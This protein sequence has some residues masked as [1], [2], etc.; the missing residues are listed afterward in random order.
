MPELVSIVIDSVEIQKREFAAITSGQVNAMWE[1]IIAKGL[2][3]K[4]L[5][6]ENIPEAFS[7]ALEDQYSET[8]VSTTGEH[9]PYIRPETLQRIRWMIHYSSL[10]QEYK[11][12]V[13]F[14]LTTIDDNR[15]DLF[16]IF[17]GINAGIYPFTIL[18]LNNLIDEFLDYQD[19]IFSNYV[20]QNIKIKI[21]NSVTV[22]WLRRIVEKRRSLAETL[23]SQS[24]TL[25]DCNV[26]LSNINEAEEVAQLIKF[27][28]PKQHIISTPITAAAAGDG[29]YTNYFALQ[30]ELTENKLIFQSLSH[31]NNINH[32]I[33]I[34]PEGFIFL[35][36]VYKALAPDQPFN[37][38]FKSCFLDD[39]FFHHLP[40]AIILDEEKI[41]TLAN[42]TEEL[43]VCNHE[44]TPLQQIALEAL[45][46]NSTKLKRL[47]LTS[48]Y[49]TD[50]N[51]ATIIETLDKNLNITYL[52]LRGNNFTTAGMTQ[53][54]NHLIEK[55]FNLCNFYTDLFEDD[56]AEK[57]EHI[58][59]R[60]NN[61]KRLT[62]S[63]DRIIG[64]ITD[65][66]LVY[67]NEAINLLM[68]YYS[69]ALGL[70][71]YYY[72]DTAELPQK[73]K[74]FIADTVNRWLEEVA[75]IPREYLLRCNL[76]LTRLPSDKFPEIKLL[77]VIL[78]LKKASEFICVE[79]LLDVTLYQE[80][81]EIRSN[82]LYRDNAAVISRWQ[83]FIAATM[84][85]LAYQTTEYSDDSI[86]CFLYCYEFIKRL[87]PASP[88]TGINEVKVT[89]QLTIDRWII[90]APS[91][92]E[93]LV[94]CI[95]LLTKLPKEK[96]LEEL[97]DGLSQ[98]VINLIAQTLAEEMTDDLLR[99]Y[100]T[101]RQIIFAKGLY[102][103]S[104]ELLRVIYNRLQPPAPSAP[105][106]TF[107][108]GRTVAAAAAAAAT[109][110][111]PSDLN[112]SQQSMLIALAIRIINDF[113]DSR[114]I[115]GE[116]N[117][118][119]AIIENELMQNFM[120][121]FIDQMLKQVT[122]ELQAINFDPMNYIEPLA[123]TGGGG[124][125]EKSTGSSF[126]SAAKLHK[127][128]T[129]LRLWLAH[130]TPALYNSIK[131]QLFCLSL[132]DRAIKTIANT[133]TV[134]F[135]QEVK[136]TD[137]IVPFLT[138]LSTSTIISATSET[139][140]ANLEELYNYID[141]YK[142]Q[143]ASHTGRAVSGFFERSDRYTSRTAIYQELSNQ[144][145]LIVFECRQHPHCSLATP[146]YKKARLMG[147]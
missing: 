71:K 39:S 10:H 57:I 7:R 88:F 18:Y 101:A 109:T 104:A 4:W 146:F 33:I 126:I 49:L 122:E 100:Q 50:A 113:I 5:T 63:K 145:R 68:T 95:N 133:L 121:Y 12:E 13:Q 16:N 17:N 22:S 90:T 37:F 134:R 75:E 34:N 130:L 99:L 118:I 128:L 108:V 30:I 8:Y 105:P 89:M 119:S 53:L 139:I 87:T 137:P 19:F 21:K 91:L 47:V 80:S 3:A 64:L 62:T 84:R 15:I 103:Y 116:E 81:Y 9:R 74:Y 14:T 38:I 45:L 78:K 98:A 25:T 111:R 35:N 114:E 125:A 60:N 102:Y 23:S 24:I 112:L 136:I 52:N 55:N 20:L 85:V 132:Q 93:K 11:R 41:N 36:K 144:L 27:L 46:R 31:E 26:E 129:T 59:Y 66:N 69:T 43:S 42:A 83:E 97:F 77:F 40:E 61:F 72:P 115:E 131:L 96:R 28:S 92:Q 110:A 32:S 117:L 2:F 73:L 123:G 142:L 135:L 44:F 79:S 48:C 143:G 54:M 29:N 141:S 106:N 86:A 67:T 65:T 127:N 51:I 6:S 76:L 94:R 56:I 120:C 1:H 82:P 140:L 138:K 58:L 147:C 124:S 70:K 107:L